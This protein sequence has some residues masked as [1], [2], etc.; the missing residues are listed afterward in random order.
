MKPTV[1]IVDSSTVGR[2][3]AKVAGDELDCVTHAVGSGK[4][5]LESC[6]N[7][8]PD[9]V[10]LDCSLPD[11]SADQFTRSLTKLQLRRFPF[12]L[13][14]GEN[15][16]ALIS[17]YQKIA[18]AQDFLRKP[19]QVHAFKSVLCRVIDMARTEAT[20]MPGTE[21]RKKIAAVR[22]MEAELIATP[23]LQGHVTIAAKFLELGMVKDASRH[24]YAA[25]LL[26]SPPDRIAILA[27]ILKPNHRL[28]TVLQVI[29]SHRLTGNLVLEL[30]N[31][32]PSYIYFE[33]GR[34]LDAIG[35]GTLSGKRCIEV[36]LAHTGGEYK[37]F[38]MPTYHNDNIG[39]STEELLLEFAS[40][41][42]EGS[43]Q[44]DQDTRN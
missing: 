9:V 22:K 1:L 8:H 44:Q 6:G 26:E 18:L 13:V 19:Y 14:T 3:M 37:F 5:G 33:D 39:Q 31:G 32:G 12:L 15:I 21:Q 2:A 28:Y 20:V 29:S 7:L 38:E 36:C 40:R 16:S 23:N 41:W 43:F 34:I 11:M 35:P 10:V 17:A 24:Y 25:A 42:D 27:G 4:M 30:G